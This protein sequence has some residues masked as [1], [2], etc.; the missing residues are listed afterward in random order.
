MKSLEI[1][2]SEKT[3]RD[4]SNM[5]WRSDMTPLHKNLVWKYVFFIIVILFL[6][7]LGGIFLDFVKC[8]WLKC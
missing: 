8:G 7:G 5:K 6:I 1:K 2:I 4:H 3:F